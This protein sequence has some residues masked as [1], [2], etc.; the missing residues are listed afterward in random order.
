[1]PST[2]QYDQAWI[3]IDGITHGPGTCVL[4]EDAGRPSPQPSHGWSGQFNFHNEVDTSPLAFT[5]TRTR[6]ILILDDGR[7][8]EILVNDASTELISGKS[9]FTFLGQGE[10]FTSSKKFLESESIE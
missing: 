7:Q 1:M 3:M 10:L 5:L 6:I 8:G 4:E 2:S 9:A